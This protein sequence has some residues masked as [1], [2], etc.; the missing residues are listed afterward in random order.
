V[1]TEIEPIADDNE[2]ATYA[3]LIFNQDAIA[4]VLRAAQPQKHPR[5]NGH[6]CVDCGATIP[7]ERLNLGRVLCVDCQEIVEFN[8]RRYARTVRQTAWV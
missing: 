1:I 6:S 2:R 8:R 4:A 3:E 7:Q 5:F